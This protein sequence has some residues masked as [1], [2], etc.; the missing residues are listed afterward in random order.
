MRETQE[1]ADGKAV[2]FDPKDYAGPIRRITI[3]GIDLVALIA[4][5]FGAAYGVVVWRPT[6]AEESIGRVLLLMLLAGV[7]L[8]VVVFRTQKYIGRIDMEDKRRR[9]GRQQSEK[10][11]ES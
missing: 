9:R 3:L 2:Y 11:A 1:T 10:G 8:A 7:G 5:A 6:L 4:I